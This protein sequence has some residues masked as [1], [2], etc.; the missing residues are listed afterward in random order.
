MSITAYILDGD[1]QI[2]TTE[3]DATLRCDC[4]RI[5]TERQWPADGISCGPGGHVVIEPSVACEGC[6]PHEPRV[7]FVEAP[8]PQPPPATS[9]MA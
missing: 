5:Y 8:P 3:P 4:G 6:S 7:V 9:G 2:G 1:L